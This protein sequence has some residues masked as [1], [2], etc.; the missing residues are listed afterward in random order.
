[1]SF[2]LTWPNRDKKTG[3]IS[4]YMH[5]NMVNVNNKYSVNDM[6]TSFRKDAMIFSCVA[7]ANPTMKGKQ[8]FDL[9]KDADFSAINAKNATAFDV[10]LYSQACMLGNIMTCEQLI[11]VVDGSASITII[12]DDDCINYK[13]V[14]EGDAFDKGEEEE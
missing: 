1:M 8:I 13:V 3:Q 11:S 12:G 10:R 5:P 4:F 9:L 14:F 6:N 7:R 2:T